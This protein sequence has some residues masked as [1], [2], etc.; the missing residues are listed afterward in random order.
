VGHL[1]T[2]EGATVNDATHDREHPS[3]LIQGIRFA[4]FTT[5]HRDGHLHA[6]P[7][8]AQ[9][10]RGDGDKPARLFKMAQAAVTRQPPQLGEHGRLA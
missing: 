6:C 1:F 2:D 9:R 7:T 10:C 4:M 3:D 5:P 8:T